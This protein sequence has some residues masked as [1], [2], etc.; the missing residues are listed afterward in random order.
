MRLLIISNMRHYVDDGKVMGW[1]PTAKEI[2][3]LASL[4]TEVVH[5]GCL[6]TGPPPRSMVAYE[7]PNIRL[8][9]VPPAGG[10]TLR[11]KLDIVRLVPLYLRAILRE[12]P[13]ADVVHVRCPANISLL[14]LLALSCLR[15]PTRR[16][17]KY[18]GNWRPA[19]REAVSYTLQ[20]WYLQRG[21]HRGVVTVN[22]EWPDQPKHV[23]SFLNPCVTQR[24]LADAER[25]TTLKQ[26][27]S[28]I[29]LIFVGRVEEPKGAGRAVEVL[30]ELRRQGCA[31]RL[32]LV[33]EGPGRQ[34]FE[35]LAHEL[36]VQ[37]AVVFHGPLPRPEISELYARCH[38]ILLPSRCS[39][40]WPKVLSEAMAY[41]A[42]PIAGAVSS[43][44]QY[45]ERF[46]VGAVCPPQDIGAY[47]E[48]VRRYAAD[49]AGW[50]AQSR[51]AAQQAAA[52]TYERYLE[53]VT[54]ILCLERPGTG[55]RR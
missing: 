4:F 20:R 18:A 53:R 47:V 46:G 44:P 11:D 55:G 45:L 36:G 2:D 16:W 19:G 6:H 22:G 51:L 12:V 15:R 5:I 41:G 33:G 21:L 27:S 32:H 24:E 23:H 17:V 9:P 52:F 28:P 34:E 49:P 31:A 26:L 10:S 37:D 7:A 50:K 38:V 29:E 35:Q 39:E 8:I 48:A 42:V 30:A 43:I 40:G 54:S 14:A 25:E 13:R 1:G 3:Y